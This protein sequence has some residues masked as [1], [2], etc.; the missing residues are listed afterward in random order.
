[1]INL[2]N[3]AKIAS[4]N[5]NSIEASLVRITFHFIPKKFRGYFISTNALF[6]IAFLEIPF[7][8]I[9]KSYLSKSSNQI[10]KNLKTL[11]QNH[12]K[13][14][15]EIKRDDLIKLYGNDL[16]KYLDDVITN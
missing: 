1:M 14:V 16:S 2:T 12:Y 10:E 11:L 13:N 3:I 15:I 4:E 8:S 5:P 9:E 7:K 6:N